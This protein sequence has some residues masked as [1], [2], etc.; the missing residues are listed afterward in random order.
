MRRLAA[1]RLIAVLARPI[2]PWETGRRA[3]GPAGPRSR[4]A[5]VRRAPT[6]RRD[7][8]R[9]C[10]NARGDGEAGRRLVRPSLGERMEQTVAALGEVDRAFSREDLRPVF[11]DQLQLFERFFPMARKLVSFARPRRAA[12]TARSPR[13]A[14]RRAFA[15]DPPRGAAPS[16]DP[17][18]PRIEASRQDSRSVGS[19]AGGTGSPSSASSAPADPLVELR[20]ADRDQPGQ[21][22]SAAARAHERIG[23]RPDRAIV[24][25]EDSPAR[26][27]QRVLAEARRS[28]PAASASA[29]ERCDGMV[30]T[31]TRAASDML[32][33]RFRQLDRLGRA[34]IEPQALVDGTE[35]AALR[36]SPGPTGCWSR[37]G[38]RAHR[39]AGVWTRSGCR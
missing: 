13:S 19:I 37:T 24:G 11:V 29:K 17:S 16:A 26:E 22:Q 34:D 32:E 36:R 23:D 25:K 8:R 30:K 12:A 33:R 2:R 20:V 3:K 15:R 6:K 21:Q 4:P 28:S 27:T 7:R 9:C 10:R 14:R 31:A 18:P 35:A 1:A 5:C 38:P 39:G